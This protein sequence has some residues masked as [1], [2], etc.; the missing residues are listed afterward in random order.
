[1]KVHELIEILSK[2]DQ[3]KKILTKD[4]AAGFRD[5]DHIEDSLGVNYIL[6]TKKPKK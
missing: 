6:H 2:L 1:M 4:T 5:V 3:N